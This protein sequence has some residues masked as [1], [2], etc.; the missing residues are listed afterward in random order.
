MSLIDYRTVHL[1]STTD[2]VAWQIA[3]GTDTD[4][5]RLCIKLATTPTTLEDVTITIQYNA[6]SQ[7]NTIIRALPNTSDDIVLENICGI[8]SADNIL[9][10]YTN[11]DGVSV[12]GSCTIRRGE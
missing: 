2:A 11:T 3:L 6:G 9:V 7:Y 8:D 10:E 12:A 1:D 5:E 4:I